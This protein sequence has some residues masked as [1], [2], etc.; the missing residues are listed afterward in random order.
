MSSTSGWFFSAARRASL[1]RFVVISPMIMHELLLPQTLCFGAREPSWATAPV[2]CCLARTAATA[3]A[4]PLCRARLA[5]RDASGTFSLTARADDPSRAVPTDLACQIAAPCV[6]VSVL[7]REVL[8]EF[9]LLEEVPY[10]GGQGFGRLAL[11][12]FRNEERHERPCREPETFH[13]KASRRRLGRATGS[14]PPARQRRA[15]SCSKKVFSSAAVQRSVNGPPCR[16]STRRHDLVAGDSL[17]SR[18]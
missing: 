18:R 8:T 17:L 3:C 12:V 1:S 6:V 14:F 5:R 13:L 11:T 9:A 7:L 15:H 4:R 16:P 2:R 10:V